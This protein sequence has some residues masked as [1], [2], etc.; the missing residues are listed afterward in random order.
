MPC[1]AA[2]ASLT[3]GVAAAQLGGTDNAPTKPASPTPAGRGSG[4]AR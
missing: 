4:Q 1:N 2:A 3:V